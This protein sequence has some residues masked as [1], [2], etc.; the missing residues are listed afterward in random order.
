MA[1][2]QAPW[3]LWFL[4]F[5]V[6]VA[7]FWQVIK[8]IR[9]W[10][11]FRQGWM[12]GLGYFAV[13]L[14]W[15][16]E[17][18]LV[19]VARHGWM[20]PFALVF[21]AG[22]L[23]LF[24]GLAFALA[25]VITPLGPAR[26]ALV[27]TL[28]GAEAARSFVLTGF[29]WALIGHVWIDT[30][31]AQTAAFIGAHGLT[32]LTLVAASCTAWAAQR[33]NWALAGLPV[34]ALAFVWVGFAPGPAPLPAPD[35]PV[36][37][38]VQPNAPQDQKWDPVMM[39]VFTQ[40]LIDLSRGAEGAPQPALVVWPETAVPWLLDQS[41]DLLEAAADATRGAPLAVGAMRREGGRYFNA[42]A[43]VAGD[44]T[45]AQVYD[46]AH[47]VPFGEYIPFGEIAA[48][49]GIH[50]LAASEGGG[51]TA[52]ASTG[53]PMELPGIGL[54]L[55]LICYEGIFA[56]KVNGAAIRPRLLLLITNDA[57]FGVLSG[58][59]QHL[60][61]GRLRA[62]EQGLPMVRVANTGVTAMIDAQG[63]ITGQIALGQMGALDLPLPAALA[64][65][66]YARA[67]DWPIWGL[68]AALALAL[69]IDR[70]RKGH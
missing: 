29:P 53:Q 31:I 14:H 13:A 55:P 50:G 65:T 10:P 19:D 17:P 1:L 40:R 35:A 52:G 23:A 26:A 43:L 54:A 30:G 24:W 49:F 51:F 61:Q 48:R 16:I 63:R 25:R 21:M 70:R 2:G 57:W 38:L 20:A 59:Y 45:V 12:L 8:P 44:G 34:A 68:L 33:R 9:F 69:A 39:P 22:G 37:R 11:A 42:L 64:P 58:P 15:I 3:G 4:T 7:L 47:L 41:A 28:T 67:G 60:A 27:L 62:I 66:I 46:K 5:A 6:L 32:L 56:Q 36:I 18:F